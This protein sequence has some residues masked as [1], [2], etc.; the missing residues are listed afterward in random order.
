M[1]KIVN[2][3]KPK[4]DT[5][6]LLEPDLEMTTGYSGPD[7]VARK[8]IITCKSMNICEMYKEFKEGTEDNQ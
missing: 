3:L 8:I 6:H 7:M 2:E 1:N 5:C 4:C